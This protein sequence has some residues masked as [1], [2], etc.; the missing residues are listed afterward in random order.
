MRR[1]SSPALTHTGTGSPAPA[2]RV[3]G[4]SPPSR[5]RVSSPVTGTGS[6]LAV[7]GRV[8]YYGM[9]CAG[10]VSG[11]GAL[12]SGH[13]SWLEQICNTFASCSWRA[14]SPCQSVEGTRQCAT[15]PSGGRSGADHGGASL[16]RPGAGAVGRVARRDLPASPVCAPSSLACSKPRGLC[17]PSTSEGFSGQ[18][19]SESDLPSHLDLWNKMRRLASARTFLTTL[20]TRTTGILSW[21]LHCQT[22]RTSS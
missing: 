20:V 14:G 15:R 6:G 22:S 19:R 17:S 9:Y 18:V 5:R 7:R 21:P 8:M 3:C 1:V 12:C 10:H 16:R 4:R 2:M 13:S 11:E